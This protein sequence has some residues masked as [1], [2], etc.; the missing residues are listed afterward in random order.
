MKNKVVRVL[1]IISA[2]IILFGLLL[3]LGLTDSLL[4]EISYADGRLF[5]L[6]GVFELVT[7]RLLFIVASFGIVASIW[8]V[9]GFCVLFRKIKAE[10]FKGKRLVLA[11]LVIMPILAFGIVSSRFIL[12]DRF[13]YNILYQDG[14]SRYNIYKTNNRVKVVA[15]EQVACVAMPCPVLKFVRKIN[16]SNEGMKTVNDFID[17]LFQNNTYNSIQIFAENLNSEQI[18]ML[19]SVIHNDEALLQSEVDDEEKYLIT[20]DERWWTMQ[21]DGGTHHSTYYEINL[22]KSNVTKYEDYYV[23]F[24]GYEY[25]GR[26][27]YNKNIDDQ[28]RNEASKLLNYLLSTEDVN[29]TKNYNFYVIEFSNSDLVYIYNEESIASLRELLDEIDSF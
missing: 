5:Q 9:Y 6:F 1:L 21:N 12:G 15:E 16:F 19:K 23:G 14:A 18:R 22:T 2:I 26:V 29:E 10:N 27:I 3:G 28:L 8:L 4:D 25:Q 17:S 11:I 7:L 24:K 13:D 20:T